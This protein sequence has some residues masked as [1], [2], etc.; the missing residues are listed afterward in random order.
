MR[1]G[2][3]PCSLP[4]VKDMTASRRARV[5]HCRCW[6]RWSSTR[7]RQR[8]SLPSCSAC[9]SSPCSVGAGAER[10]GRGDRY[11]EKHYRIRTCTNKH[12]EL[13]QIKVGCV[14]PAGGLLWLDRPGRGVGAAA[15]PLPLPGRAPLLV[16]VQTGRGAVGA[17][18]AQPVPLRHGTQA[19]AGRVV[20]RGAGI[21][22]QQLACSAGQGAGQGA[23]CTSDG[24]VVSPF[25][26]DSTTGGCWRW[27]GLACRLWEL[28][29]NP[30]W[31]P[32]QA[33]HSSSWSSDPSVAPTMSSDP[34]A[35]ATAG[36]AAGHK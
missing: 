18:W 4:A 14:M 3:G 36:T 15:A 25:N 34:A 8:P 17:D 6:R 7:R 33:W 32:P 26:C 20:Y 19:A 16:L 35:A 1:V 29:G 30:P 9:C 27:L 22:A 5:L 12:V 31:S 10:A 23:V 21:A 11:R 13:N 28:P 2:G 24:D